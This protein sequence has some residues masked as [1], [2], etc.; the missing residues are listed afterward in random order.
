MC[1]W[2][3]LTIYSL[4]VR[5]SGVLGLP[6]TNQLCLPT[7]YHSVNSLALEDLDCN[8]S[9]IA[10]MC[11]LCACLF[12]VGHVRVYRRLAFIR[13]YGNNWSFLYVCFYK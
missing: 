11:T 9:E 12:Y 6:Y 10:Y 8:S 4:F 13:D 1:L 5:S 7:D 2:Y 3:F